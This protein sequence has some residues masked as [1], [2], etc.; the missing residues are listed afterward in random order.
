MR[1]FDYED[2]DNEEIDKFL[3]PESNEYLI[4]PE[5]YKQ[6]LADELSLY[7]AQ[8]KGDSNKINHKIFLKSIKF[9][10]N[11]FWWKFCSLNT[12][13][14]HVENTYKKFK[15]LLEIEEEK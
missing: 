9:L 8:S 14:N 6:I 10:E 12:K 3:D 5:E 7:E 11:S 15:Q 4:T 1:R 13:L 2:E